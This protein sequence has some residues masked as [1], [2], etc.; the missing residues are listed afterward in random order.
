MFPSRYDEFL[1]EILN[2]AFIGGLDRVGVAGKQYS[3]QRKIN[4]WFFQIKSQL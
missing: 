1:D 4:N 2:V 3:V